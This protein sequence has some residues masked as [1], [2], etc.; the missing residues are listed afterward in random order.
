[1]VA[2]IVSVGTELLLGQIADTNAQTL[3]K[4]LPEYGIEHKFR[5]TVGDN[6]QRLTDALKLAVSRS[7]IV[8]TIG[9]LGPTA[10]DL[11]R[12]G[13]AAALGDEL[14]LDEAI[15]AHLKHLF[16]VRK[17]QWLDMQNRQAM[18]PTCATPIENPNGTAPGLLCQKEGKVVIAMPGPKGEFGPMAN[19]PVRD[20][21][22]KHAGGEV[23]HSRLLRICGL[24]ESTVE[25]KIRPLLDATN[26]TVAPYAQV[27]EVH[28]RVTAKAPNVDLAEAMIE[29]V[30]MRI[31]S[32]LDDAV[33]G[34]GDTTLEKA[35]IDLL[36]GRKETVAVAE[37]ITGGGVGAQLTAV[38]GS[39]DAFIGGVITY[40]PE[41]KEKLLGVDSG[42]LSDPERGPV[43]PQV[44]EQM[45]QGVRKL[46]N[47]TYGVS[48]TGNAGPA[49]DQGGKPVGLVYL[50]V[51]WDGGVEVQEY[52]WR[53]QRED[54]RRR[55]SQFALTLLRSVVLRRIQ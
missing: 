36:V 42:I 41:M 47:S 28:L 33:Y 8:F 54:I 22:L 35:L 17:M 38:A 25:D 14:V 44:A 21:L 9:G 26:P 4:I 52:R 50:A 15:S 12:E 6:V 29:P 51:A 34:S 43:D 27:G 31:R 5:Q 18:R 45:A 32:V 19:G 7:D 10:D 20:F 40:Q 1:M 11:T 55:A 2:E 39:G 37:S 3:G 49:A 24:G 48:L 53:G 30:E 13:I 46:C 16:E 23:I